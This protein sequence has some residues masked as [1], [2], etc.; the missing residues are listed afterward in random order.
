MSFGTEN[1]AVLA[2]LRDLTHDNSNFGCYV[3]P[4]NYLPSSAFAGSDETHCSMLACGQDVSIDWE[5]QMSDWLIP[6]NELDFVK[7]RAETL[8]LV[9]DGHI[10]L[11]WTHI[12]NVLS[13]SYM[14]TAR[15]ARL[16]LCDA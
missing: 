13:H 11:D 2:A 3:V 7:Q 15:F 14:D 12:A 5:Q 9:G 1:N 6:F 10:A 16:I 8:L 4:T